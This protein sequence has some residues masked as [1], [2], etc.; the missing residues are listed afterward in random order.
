MQKWSKNLLDVAI[1]W[2]AQSNY[3]KVRVDPE[4]THPSLKKLFT[5]TDF[6]EKFVRDENSDT[7]VKALEKLLVSLPEYYQYQK[8]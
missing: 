3:K 7:L 8:S 4:A 5:E 1:D 6:R 2:A